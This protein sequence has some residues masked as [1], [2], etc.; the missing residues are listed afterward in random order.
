MLLLWYHRLVRGPE[1]SEVVAAAVGG[2]DGVPQAATGVLTAI[3]DRIGDQPFG[4]DDKRR[5]R[6]NSD[7]SYWRQRTTAH[8]AL[9]SWMPDRWDRELSVSCS[10]E[11]GK[12]LFLIH[13]RIV[14]RETRNPYARAPA[15]CS[16][17]GRHTR[18]PAR[19]F[20]WVGMRGRIF[21]A[22]SSEQPDRGISVCRPALDRCARVRHSD[23]ADNEADC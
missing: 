16:V 3:P 18:S 6:S 2:F 14:V 22:L 4:C 10:M 23:N 19:A 8:R 9:T 12:R 17:L 5:S 15:G 21:P 7:S 11:A 20:L 13:A 1:I